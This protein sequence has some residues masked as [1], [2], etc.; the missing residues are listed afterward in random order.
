MLNVVTVCNT[1]QSV[2][3]FIKIADL[4]QQSQCYMYSQLW[5]DEVMKS[6]EINYDCTGYIR[7]EYTLR[8]ISCTSIQRTLDLDLVQ[9]H[10]LLKSH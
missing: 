5:N 6:V 1:K 2:K 7:G 8:F 4:Y 3:D 10:L 9:L